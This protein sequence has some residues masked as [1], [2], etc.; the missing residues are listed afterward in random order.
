[1]WFFPAED[2]AHIAAVLAQDCGKEWGVGGEFC[3][4]ELH[5]HAAL[6]HPIGESG[7]GAGQERAFVGVADDGRF[8]C[9]EVFY[10][11][12]GDVMMRF[13]RVFE[14]VQAVEEW[15]GMLAHLIAD[16]A[17]MVT[18]CT[19][20]EQVNAACG[21]AVLQDETGGLVAEIVW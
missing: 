15:L 2:A 16:Q 7:F 10:R 13:E 18:G 6:L 11:A 4:S 12:N 5:Q 19:G 3:A 8:L 17:D 21:V 20:I 14:I 9:D 1:L